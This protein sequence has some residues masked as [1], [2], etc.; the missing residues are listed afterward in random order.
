[1]TSWVADFDWPL[2]ADAGERLAEWTDALK[3]TDG[4][5]HL[6]YVDGSVMATV[7]LEAS[8]LVTA[9]PLASQAVGTFFGRKPDLRRLRLARDRSAPSAPVSPPGDRLAARPA[10]DTPAG[11]VL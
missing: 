7:T 3:R 1:M 4:R 11:L 9:L 8:S 6:H 2:A 10:P 5:I